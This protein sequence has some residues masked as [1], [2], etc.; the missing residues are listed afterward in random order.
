MW[1]VKNLK[2][3]FNKKKTGKHSSYKQNPRLPTV[4]VTYDAV[5]NQH[6]IVK[7]IIRKSCADWLHVVHKSR[8]NVASLLCPKRKI[9][10]EL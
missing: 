9:V 7:N 10:N 4:T 3:F 2:K 6:K 5:T 1:F 8:K